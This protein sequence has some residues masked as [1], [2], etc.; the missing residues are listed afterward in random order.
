MKITVDNNEEDDDNKDDD[1]DDLFVR[2][3]CHINSISV[4]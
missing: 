1:D 3:K 2:G 4:T